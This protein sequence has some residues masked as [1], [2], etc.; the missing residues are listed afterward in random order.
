[1]LVIWELSGTK[2]RVQVVVYDGDDDGGGQASTK[3]VHTSTPPLSYI[4]CHQSGT[5]YWRLGHG[6]ERVAPIPITR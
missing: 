1:M 6:N 2:S 5:L 4:I 3:N